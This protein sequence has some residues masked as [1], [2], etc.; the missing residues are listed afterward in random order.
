MATHASSTLLLN[1][2]NSHLQSTRT[3][4]KPW[5]ITEFS[6]DSR[7]QCYYADQRLFPCTFIYS[8]LLHVRTVNYYY[9][10]LFLIQFH[11][12][13]FLLIFVNCFCPCQLF[14]WFNMY[15]YLNISIYLIEYKV[16]NMFR[17]KERILDKW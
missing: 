6:N 1:K 9:F 10:L 4:D 14:G 5:R 17:P 11:L 8:H 16:L 2:L 15:S 13:A 3:S 7:T 12:L